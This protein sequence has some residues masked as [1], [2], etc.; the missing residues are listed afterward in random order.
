MSSL[1]AFRNQ[2]ANNDKS[3]KQ[4]SLLFFQLLKSS[5]PKMKPVDVGAGLLKHKASFPYAPFSSSMIGGLTDTDGLHIW[6]ASASLLEQSLY[7]AVLPPTGPLLVMCGPQAGAFRPRPMLGPVLTTFH[8]SC[9][10]PEL[11]AEGQRSS[12]TPPISWPCDSGQMKLPP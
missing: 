2:L 4:N 11:E 12:S 9:M 7:M 10:S 8:P 3:R 1:Q 6:T 5:C